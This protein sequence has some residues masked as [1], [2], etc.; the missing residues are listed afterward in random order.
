MQLW[1]RADGAQRHVGVEGLHIIAAEAA[2]VAVP[3]GDACEHGDKGISG[4]FGIGQGE[5]AGIA[6]RLKDEM[7]VI[8]IR[9]AQGFEGGEVFGGEVAQ[10]HIGDEHRLGAVQM[11]ADVEAGELS[12]ALGG[13]MGGGQIV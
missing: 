2:I 8:F 11:I 6:A 13:G 9:A 5:C 4:E 3:I 10:F 7:Q 12:E 1:M